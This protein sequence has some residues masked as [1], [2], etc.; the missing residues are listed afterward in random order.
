MIC[1]RCLKNLPDAPDGASIHT[2]KP[3]DLVRKLEQQR[4]SMFSALELC[5]QH[6]AKDQWDALFI[7][8]VIAEA[9]EQK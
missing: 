4:N 1:Q 9:K 7:D 2:C 3:S 5:K 6:M 8:G